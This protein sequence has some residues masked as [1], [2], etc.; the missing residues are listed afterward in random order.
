M[1][2]CIYGSVFLYSFRKSLDFSI[3]F[4]CP[5][6]HMS[7]R[8]F[9]LLSGFLFMTTILNSQTPSVQLKIREKGFLRGERIVQIELSNQNRQAPLTSENVNAGQYYFFLI[10]PAGD[11][12]LDADFVKEQLGKV[13]VYQNEKKEPIAWN[14]EIIA[15]GNNSI[16]VG[17]AKTIKLNQLFLFQ[18]PIDDAMSQVEFKVPQEFWP[19]FTLVN[20]LAKQAETAGT[21]RRYKSA[22]TSY[23]Q[24]LANATLKIFAQYDEYKSKRTQCFDNFY[25]ETSAAFQAAAANAQMDLKARIALVDGFKPTFKY[26]L[27]SLPR[28]EW[29]IGSLDTAVAP[30]LDRCRFS[31]AQAT[32]FRDSLQHAL[33]DQNVRWIIEGSATSKNGYRYVNII[34]TLASAFSSVNFADTLVTELKTRIPEEHRAR[35]AKYND[36]ESYETFIRICNERW[37]THLP[38]FPIDFLPN[39]KKDTISFAQPYYSML[40]AVND[41]YYGNFTSAKEEILQI[42]RKC[43]DPEIIGRFD[44]LRVIITD[45]ELHISPDVMKMLDEAE[46]LERAKD[47]QNAKDKYQQI[48]LI[49]PNFAY[50]FFAQ[51][52]FYNRSG[53]PIRANYSFQKA[54]QID[55]LYL[56]AYRESCNLFL[57]QSNFKEIINVLTTAISRG[58]DFWEIN[59]RLGVAFA[60]D[61]DPARAILSFER[62]LALNPRS[63]QTNIQIGL[64]HQNVKNYQKAREYFNNAIGLDPT[65]QEAVDFLTK[66]NE[67]QRTGK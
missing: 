32:S 20:D 52:K 21:A 49:A 66:L 10:A 44:M 30:I 31:L 47:V 37:Q 23:E 46:Q 65:K 40:K 36:T 61:A 9:S 8:F 54:Y 5:R 24:I 58:N 59:Y 63:Y 4:D 3:H 19:G 55:T 50:G 39:L 28:A 62:A 51:G 26:I 12:V 38:I 6:F 16:L 53:D 57:K 2:R 60:G 17:F 48:T 42:F 33:D 67:L 25:N 11:W 18:C 7:T 43:Y 64:A 15:G 27:D 34:E 56:S 13:T 35:L 41:Y 29:N 1:N 14:G 45:R 22:I